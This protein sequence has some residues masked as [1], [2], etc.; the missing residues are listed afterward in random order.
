MSDTP[1][2]PIADTQ[3]AAPALLTVSAPPHDVRRD[4]VARIMLIAFAALVPASVV[5]VLL[6]G[7]HVLLAM[8]LGL[9]AA[10]ATEWIITA[11]RRRRMVLIDG[12]ACV[13]G[14]LLALSLPPQAPL[15]LAPLGGVF[16]IAV[17]KMALD[18]L[19]RNFLNPALAGRAFLAISFPAV[20]A[21]AASA[22]PFPLAADARA[23]LD[24]F[25]GYQG[26]WIG[27]VSAAALLAGAAALWYFRIIDFSLPIAFIA[28]AFAL[29]WVDGGSGGLFTAVA[30]LS[31]LFDVVTGGILLAA[32]FMATDPVTSPTGTAARILAG[33][34]CGAMVW[35]FHAYGQEANAPMYAILIMNCLVPW[36]DRLF[37][38]RPLGLRGKKTGAE[39]A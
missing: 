16:A 14:L 23:F 20:F 3:A 25:I 27:S 22:A 30:L 9:S 18:G 36:L 6:Y 7:T 19:G 15:W 17:A 33:A 13:T 8:L 32:L 26:L 4:S 35:I 12:S 31:P 5:P 2:V 37:V 28:T 29:F 1:A 24:L 21:T 34:G 39:G 10:A 11:I 38:R